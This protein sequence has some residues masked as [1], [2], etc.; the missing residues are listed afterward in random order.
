MNDA[1][2]NGGEMNEDANSTVAFIGTQNRETCYGDYVADDSINTND[3]AKA[4]SYVRFSTPEQNKGDSLRRQIELSEKYAEE[5]GLFLDNTVT[6]QDLGVSAYSGEHLKSKA[7]LGQFLM[8]VESGKITKGSVLL[9]ENLDRLSRQEI[10]KALQQFLDIIN[11]GI[12]IVTLIDNREYTEATIDVGDLII[13]LTIMARA[14]EES[15]TKSKRLAQA[16]EMKRKEINTIKLTSISPAWLRLNQTKT[17]FEVIE[18][19]KNTISRIFEMKLAGKG[20]TRIVRELNSDCES[21]KPGNENKKKRGEGWRESYVR[22]ILQNRAVI[23]E[24]QPH[25][26]SNGRRIPIGDAISEYFP[27]IIDKTSFY[28]IQ[29]QLKQNIYKGGRI[30]TVG[31]LFTHIAKCGYC[32]GPMVLVNKEPMSPNGK[33][34][35][36]DRA[37]RKSINCCNISIK[38]DEVEK[39]FLTYCKGIQL[40]DIVNEKELSFVKT[41]KNEMQGKAGE[42]KFIAK[43]IENIADS[44]ETTPDKRVR[45]ILENRLVQKL[46]QQEEINQKIKIIKKQIDD[47]SKCSINSHLALQSIKDLFHFMKHADGKQLIDT[48]LKLK[49]EIQKLVRIIKI[50]PA[51]LPFLTA[52]KA[53]QLANAA[54]E[55]FPD[56]SL[57]ELSYV[58]SELYQRVT[59]PRNFRFFHIL[60]ASGDFRTIFPGQEAPLRMDGGKQTL[61]TIL[62]KLPNGKIRCEQFDN[63][64]VLI[65]ERE[66]TESDSVPQGNTI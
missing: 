61:L 14:H 20:V 25:R 45:N 54:L 18:E 15:A 40:Q 21:W 24:F 47:L 48:R 56:T 52:D 38:Y 1:K 43:E 37:R 19:R 29:E 8:L 26:F 35:V 9:I 57:E 17:C 2:N 30:G 53:E 33:Y 16:W 44:I 39:F 3:I 55:V 22:K 4:Y 7:A 10:T 5:H 51:G 28:R 50:Y 13:S 6:F 11:K 46:D 49:N 32:G 63:G 59:K 23:G 31:N 58:R 34:L 64:E 36:C 12:K 42:S 60:F 41:L 65:T 62:R 27:P 66:A